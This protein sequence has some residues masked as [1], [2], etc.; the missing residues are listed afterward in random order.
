MKEYFEVS[1]GMSLVPIRSQSASIYFVFPRVAIIQVVN[2]IMEYDL[3]VDL[4]PDW[5][6]H[7]EYEVIDSLNPLN[8]RELIVDEYI[9]LVH[10]SRY[11]CSSWLNNEEVV[12]VDILLNLDV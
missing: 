7:G 10:E 3:E 8:S 1:D 4:I 2:Y 9:P 6:P 12:E 11:S 5:N